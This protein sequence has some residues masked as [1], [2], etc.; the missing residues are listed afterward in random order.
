VM[1]HP[2]DAIRLLLPLL[3]QE[4]MDATPP[5]MLLPPCIPA[6]QLRTVSSASTAAAF[7]PLPSFS[8]RSSPQFSLA[9]SPSPSR[10]VS[11]QLKFE[12]Q[13]ESPKHQ[14]QQ[15][16]AY[17]AQR[18][19]PPLRP[20][21]A[22]DKTS[23]LQARKVF[24][25]GIPQSIDQNALYQMCSKVGKVKKAWLQL[26]HNDRGAGKTAAP[27]KHRGFGFVIFYEKAS[28]DTLLGKD[29][30]SRMV[31]FPNDVTLE[32]KRAFGKDKKP[33]STPEEPTPVPQS[34]TPGTPVHSSAPV[35][36]QV[37]LSQQ[38]P[39]FPMPAP[40]AMRHS[41]AG[42]PAMEPQSPARHNTQLSLMQRMTHQMQTPVH[43]RGVGAMQMPF[44]SPGPSNCF[45]PAS[46][47]WQQS[48][49]GASVFPSA[50]IGQFQSPKSGAEFLPPVP[51]FPSFV[52]STQPAQPVIVTV[53]VHME[54]P[55]EP[56]RN[57]AVLT[58]Q[59]MVMNVLAGCHN[60]PNL[61]QVLLQAAPEAYED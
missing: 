41:Q 55:V 3:P 4:E 40:S 5:E 22:V 53:P 17:P 18:E 30:E 26:F 47:T 44:M 28:I 33:I 49:C 61:E 35:Q 10:P 32:V 31:N 57:Q 23:W 39:H 58:P 54:P 7:S 43:M 34:H 27:K 8:A 11:T 16:A 36:P 52:E 9:E 6:F 24:I 42:H 50:A 29:H 46:P 14:K 37:S 2:K 21:G 38:L 56:V 13:A 20:P 60:T 59:Q 25:G 45:G 19:P 51:A 15:D 1:M 48:S 12:D